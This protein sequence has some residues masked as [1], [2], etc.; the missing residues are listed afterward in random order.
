MSDKKYKVIEAVFTA[1]L[2]KQVDE[3]IAE[4]WECTGGLSVAGDTS[5]ARRTDRFFFYQAMVKK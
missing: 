4:G 5:Q 1:I 3:A 2:I